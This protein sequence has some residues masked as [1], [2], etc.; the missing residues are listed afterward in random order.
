MKKVLSIILS[1]ALT[2]SICPASAFAA[3][4]ESYDNIKHRVSDIYGLPLD[5]INSL[6]EE[7]VRRLDASEDQVVAVTEEYVNFEVQE[8][9]EA[10]AHS[11]TEEDYQEFLSS[12]AALDNSITESSSWMKIY[13]II[14]DRGTN[15][16]IASTYTWLIPPRVTVRQK[17]LMTINW[18][19]GAY[20]SA[21]GFYAYQLNG[22]RYTEY[23][24]EFVRPQDNRTSVN[25]AHPLNDSG[26]R[27]R[28]Y[29]HMMVTVRKNTGVRM[30]SVCSAYGNQYKA[31]SNAFAA[32]IAGAGGVAGAYFIDNKDARVYC[33]IAALIGL[34]PSETY[35]DTFCTNDLDFRF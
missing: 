32:T 28:E 3:E 30:E 4:A 19:Y 14:V 22:T 34:L 15:L 20:V 31:L 26:A 8:N 27:Q 23:F 12:P 6:P 24:D 1:L 10:V 7:K 2:I 16:D 21:E 11:C 9:G 35:Y 25:H 17:D 13:L 29:F 18:E 33:V 5:V